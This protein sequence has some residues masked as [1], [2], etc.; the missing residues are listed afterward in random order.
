M[1]AEGAWRGGSPALVA[2]LGVAVFAAAKALKWWAI[3]TLGLAWTF[4]VIVVPGARRITSGPYR[5]FNHPNYIA[6][7]GELAG[8]AL[9]CGAALAGSAA[10]AFFLVL[11]LKRIAVENRAVDAHLKS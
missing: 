3:L 5:F 6:V 2:V 8:A 7:V 4:R 10:T 9:T 1:I 11:I